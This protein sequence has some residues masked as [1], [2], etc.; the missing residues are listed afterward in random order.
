MVTQQEAVQVLQIALK[1]GAEF[2][3]LFFED[4]EEVNIKCVSDEIQGKKTIRI[5]GAGLYVISKTSSIYVYSN[6]C[7]YR[8]LMELAEKA[9]Q[10]IEVKEKKKIYIPTQFQTPV[11]INPN[12]VIEYPSLTG[13]HQKIRVLQ[14]TAKAAFSSGVKVLNLNI[15]YFDTDQ[16][17]RVINSEGL[18]AQDRRVTTRL[19]LQ[20]AVSDGVNSFFNWEDYTHPTGFE[21]Y[22]DEEKY[23]GF[24]VDMLKR[25]RNMMDGVSVKA[26]TVPVVLE[27][28]GCGTLWHESCG[29]SL[30]ASAIAAKSSA[31]AGKIGQKVASEKV[32]LIDDGTMPGLY[33][34]S[35][36]DDEGHLRQKNVLIKNGILQTYMCDRLHGKMIGIPSNGCGRRQNYTYAPTSRMSNTYLAA[37]D[38]D[39]DEIIRS[40]PEGLYVKSI[41]G[42]TGGM[43]FSLEVKEGWWIKNGELAYPVKGLMLTGNGIDV[44]SKI[45]RVG[46]TLAYD[47]GGFCGAASGLIPTTTFQPRV[48][49]SEMSIG[50]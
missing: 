11:A 27:A 8:G 37:G 1:S 9:A 44:I 15:D 26:C 41:G 14:Q 19:R 18:S 33:G 35:Q 24:A 40:V 45:D 12:P 32:T 36:I 38:D 28:G 42:G 13:D 10:L 43:Q 39:D 50:G 25:S 46:K 7:D 17:I 49:I 3:E 6:R 47:G 31:F 16:K 20:T 22:R 34:S 30:E 23:I 2:A 48:R 4:R 29:H 5:Y 21:A